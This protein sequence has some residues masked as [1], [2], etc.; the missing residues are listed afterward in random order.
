[1]FTISLKKIKNIMKKTKR[2]ITQI[3]TGDGKG[4]TTAALGQ[5]IR[6]I[7][8]GLSVCWVQFIKGNPAIGEKK[9]RDKLPA[10]FK[11]KFTFKQF[12]KTKKYAI[13]KP[14]NAHRVAA[15]K[16]WSFAKKIIETGKYDLIILDELNN[17]IDYN[18][19]DIDRVLTVLKN[20]PKDLE[21]VITGRDTH[22]KLVKIADL[23]TEMKKK[24]H[25]FDKGLI[26]RKGIEY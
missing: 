7:G 20:K 11:K 25:P 18:L 4:K 19:I 14:T 3:Y 9:F 16:A 22:P 17:A 24:K 21:L 15:S 6:A 26:A 23:V 1:M 2:G 10:S 8:W 13:E 5:T 12:H